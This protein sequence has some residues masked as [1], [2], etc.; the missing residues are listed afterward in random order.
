[1]LST[2]LSRVLM[3]LFEKSEIKKSILIRYLTVPLTTSNTNL[4][5]RSERGYFFKKSFKRNF[6][7]DFS[8]KYLFK[9]KNETCLGF[10]DFIGM[11]FAL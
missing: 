1:M 5:S 9:M 3:L 2:S 8:E 10:A 7:L 4:L 11:L 6:R